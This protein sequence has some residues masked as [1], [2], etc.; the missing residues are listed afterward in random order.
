V[1]VNVSSHGLSKCDCCVPLHQSATVSEYFIQFLV[2]CS[3]S[4]QLDFVFAYTSC[5]CDV[6]VMEVPMYE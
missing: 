3:S 2:T 4:S 1:V 6:C 5:R